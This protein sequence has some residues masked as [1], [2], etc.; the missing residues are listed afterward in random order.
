M[1][2]IDADKLKAIAKDA[3]EKTFY[4]TDNENERQFISDLGKFYMAIIDSAPTEDVEPKV[5][6]HWIY[7]DNDTEDYRCSV[8]G[9]EI[10]Y[11]PESMKR[12][13]YCGAINTF[14]KERNKK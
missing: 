3:I 6:G 7:T 1:R 11:P 12:C 13:L 2:Y 9:G 14:E 5:Y 8:C 4:A 10:D